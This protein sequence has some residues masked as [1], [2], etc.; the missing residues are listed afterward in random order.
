MNT[1]LKPLCTATYELGEVTTIDAGDHG[2]RIVAEILGA[3]FEGERLKASL[4]GRAAADWAAI[5]PDGRVL[6]DVRLTLKTDDGVPILV[7]YQGRGHVSSAATYS[8]PLFETGDERYAWLTRIQA[9]GKSVL[10]GSTLR[11]EMYE[12]V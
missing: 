12:V 10:E 11:Y 9:V 6:V 8:A 5:D 1:V 7:H 4:V 2:T 3:R